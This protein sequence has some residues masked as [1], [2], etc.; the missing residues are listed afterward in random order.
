MNVI[1]TRLVYISQLKNSIKKLYNW[2]FL[3]EIKIKSVLK[4][5]II[6]YKKIQ[7]KIFRY[8]VF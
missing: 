4:F 1:E 3:F 8:K 6:Y 7:D 5:N 2:D